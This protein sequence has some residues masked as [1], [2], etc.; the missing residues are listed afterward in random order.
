MPHRADLEE[1]SRLGLNTLGCVKNHHSRIRCHERTISI[2]RKVL[3]AGSIQN[4]EAV[5]FIFK[6]EDGA[7]D[8]NSSLFLQIHPVRHRM[9]ARRFSFYGA[10]SL[11]C[12]AVKQKLFRQ[13]RF[14]GVRM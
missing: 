7:C 13:R 5:T 3:V 8:G 12:P 4:V 6:L 2:L 10:R 9:P 1:L 14:T 11:N